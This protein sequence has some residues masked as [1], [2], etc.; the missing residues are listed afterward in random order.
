MRGIHLKKYYTVYLKK[1]DMV[2]ASGTSEQF[3]KQLGFKTL[4]VFYS[5]ISRIN[6]GI[7]TKY[8]V[9]IQNQDDDI[10]PP[11]ATTW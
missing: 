3:R 2:V 1:D 7:S 11:D 9:D 5:V 6:R 8:E 10:E 4:G